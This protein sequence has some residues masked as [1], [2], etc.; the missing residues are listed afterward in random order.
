[1]QT[2]KIKE[3]EYITNCERRAREDRNREELQK[4]PLN[5]KQNGRV[6]GWPIG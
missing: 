1:M 5:K 3:S 2:I 6:P 4:Q